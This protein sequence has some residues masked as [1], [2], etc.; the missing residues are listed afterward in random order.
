MSRIR[1]APRPVSWL[2]LCL[3][4]ASLSACGMA[5]KEELRYR[6]SRLLPALAVPEGMAG[7]TYSSA[8]EIPAAGMSGAAAGDVELPPDLRGG[9]GEASVGEGGGE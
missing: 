7:P 4:A 6:D 8:M 2:M 5:N 9:A 3:L 1:R